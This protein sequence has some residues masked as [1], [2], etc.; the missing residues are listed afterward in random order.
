[1]RLSIEA[2]WS[3]VLLSFSSTELIILFEIHLEKISHWGILFL[4][5]HYWFSS[6]CFLVAWVRLKSLDLRTCWLMKLF[7]FFVY[8]WV[9]TFHPKLFTFSLSWSS[10]KSRLFLTCRFHSWPAVWFFFNHWLL[11]QRAVAL[12]SLYFSLGFVLQIDDSSFRLNLWHW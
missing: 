2:Y 4:F 12:Q 11:R 7:S 1:M 5:S 6:F 9:Q 3:K 10:Y 8:L